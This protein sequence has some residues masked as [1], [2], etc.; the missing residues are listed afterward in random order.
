MDGVGLRDEA[1]ELALHQRETAIGVALP[2]GARGGVLRLAPVAIGLQPLR[3]GVEG[4]PRFGRLKLAILIPD[5][6]H[7]GV[8]VD[9]NVGAVVDRGERE[10]AADH[11]EPQKPP[12][13]PPDHQPQS[14]AKS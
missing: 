13:P 2:A 12:G 4:A 9:E 8:A 6:D 7:L 11:S 10:A 5:R 3:H 14:A 1:H